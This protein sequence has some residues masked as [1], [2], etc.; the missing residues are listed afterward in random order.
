MRW[1]QTL[2]D[3]CCSGPVLTLGE[4]GQFRLDLESAAVVQDIQLLSEVLLDWK[5]WA[6]AEVGHHQSSV[7]VRVYHSPDEMQAQC[8]LT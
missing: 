4:D 6:K 7:V 3:G 1:F 8:R 2:L 5:I